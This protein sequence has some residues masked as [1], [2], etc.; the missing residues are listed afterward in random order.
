MKCARACSVAALAV[1]AAMAAQAQ[2]PA[3]T[4]GKA[5]TSGIDTSTFDK[6][7]RPQDDFFRYVNGGWIARTAIPADKASYGSFDILF[8]KSQA[9]L[10]TIIEDA[11]RTPGAPGSDSRKIGD[12]YT[13]FMD[14]A[15]VNQ[16]GITPLTRALAA[17]DAI[18]SKSE[19]ARH[20]AHMAAIDADAPLQAFVEGDFKDPKTNAAFA[21]QGGLGLPDRDYYLKDDPK[22]IRRAADHAADPGGPAGARGGR[23]RR[24]GH[25]DA[26]GEGPLDQRRDA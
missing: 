7:V 8:D 9:D 13:S 24:D 10:R 18:E 5:L 2:T 6:T 20:F 1:A 15:R 21:F 26:P 22:E 3:P 16:L 25:R 17:I 19:L 12:F 4:A 11:S 23:G 14:E